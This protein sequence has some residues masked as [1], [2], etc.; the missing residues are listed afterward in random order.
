MTTQLR[1][2][3]GLWL[4]PNPHSQVPE[5]GCELFKNVEIRHAGLVQQRR[6]FHKKVLDADIAGMGPIE[7]T[8]IDP[9][10]GDIIFTGTLETRRSNDGSEILSPLGT[11]TLPLFSAAESREALFLASDIGVGYLRS[12]NSLQRIGFETDGIA[13]SNTDPDFVTTGTVW[14]PDTHSVAY[15]ATVEKLRGNGRRVVSAPMGRVVLTNNTGN[16]ASVTF[17]LKYS[18][19][20]YADILPGDKIRV[21]RSFSVAVDSPSDEM[22]LVGEV[23][24]VP[25]QTEY[26]FLDTIDNPQLGEPLYTNPT[27]ETIAMRNVR[28]PL[29]KALGTYQASLF[30]GNIVGDWEQLISWAHSDTSNLSGEENGIGLRG[31]TGTISNGSAVITSVSDMAGLQIGMVVAGVGIAP[32]SRITIVNTGASTITMTANA[33]ASTVGVSLIFADALYIR[34]NDP[35][36]TDAF[37]AVRSPYEFWTIANKTRTNLGGVTNLP[38][39]ADI[40]ALNLSDAVPS[41]GDASSDLPSFAG[42]ARFNLV[43]G[44]K[45]GNVAFD[46]APQVWATHGDEMLPPLPLPPLNLATPGLAM[47]RRVDPALLFWSKKGQPDHFA[48]PQQAYI[49]DTDSAIYGMVSASN[50]LYVFKTDGIFTVTGAGATSGFRV[51]PF[52]LTFRAMTSRHMCE[53]DGAACCWT[54]RGVIMIHPGGRI[55]NITDGRLERILALIR[56][57]TD[58]LEYDGNLVYDRTNSELVFCL[59][60]DD[61]NFTAECFVFNTRTRTWAE[62]EINVE[63]ILLS[64]AMTTALGGDEHFG[65]VGFN[66]EDNEFTLWAPPLFADIDQPWQKYTDFGFNLVNIIL[67]EVFEDPAEPRDIA[68]IQYLHDFVFDTVEIG[69]ALSQEDGTVVAHVIDVIFTDNEESVVLAMISTDVVVDLGEAELW[70]AINN[71]MRWVSNVDAD[72][73][74]WKRWKGLHY[75]FEGSP[76][77]PMRLS[78][79]L[80]SVNG[81]NR[82]AEQSVIK[83][84]PDYFIAGTQKSS[85]LRML[86]NGGHAHSSHIVP[87]LFIKEAGSFWRLSGIVIDG[88]VVSRDVIP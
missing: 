22:F 76:R 21:W 66:N 24:I 12:A 50:V 85:V 53:A 31:T 36:Q 26:G 4:D 44:A 74:T 14:L 40:S 63:G 29:A 69:D 8:F 71:E 62:R 13:I 52:D 61:E 47:T 10:T 80:L 46:T 78:R 56:P 60:N 28:P 86:I 73:G 32:G 81:S 49:G 41:I 84:F 11:V 68:V 37:I 83:R 15:R 79:A 59:R 34:Y 42:V 67:V 55:E 16:T 39:D 2:F 30:A 1:N 87:A 54:D 70:Y 58:P 33:T 65:F 43:V 25:A 19:D 23:T 77:E 45:L 35:A 88:Q 9:D 5:G 20:I 48:T 64:T 75:T 6:G 72:I 3:S 18:D 38:N 17:V 57:E 51:D 7:Q 82:S 27:Q